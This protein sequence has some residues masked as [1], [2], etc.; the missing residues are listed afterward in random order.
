[1]EEILAK[2]DH[3]LSDYFCKM[4]SWNPYQH[5]ESRRI[6]LEIIGVP[7]Q[8][9]CRDNFEKIAYIWGELVC[10]DT[11]TEKGEN[12][13]VGKMLIDTRHL[14]TIDET[15]YMYAESLGFKIRVKECHSFPILYGSRES[16]GRNRLIDN[17]ESYE[18]E[19]DNSE[20][21]NSAAPTPSIVQDTFNAEDILEGVGERLD[22]NVDPFKDEP[23]IENCEH[24]CLYESAEEKLEELEESHTRLWNVSY[25][26]EEECQILGCKNVVDNDSFG[27]ENI[28]SPSHPPGFENCISAGNNVSNS[29]E[30]NND[31]NLRDIHVSFVLS[32]DDF[33]EVL[34]VEQIKT[35]DISEL[36]GIK[37]LEKVEKNKAGKKRKT[38]SHK[39]PLNNKGK[40]RVGSNIE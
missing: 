31:G 2:E 8:C 23:P 17:L 4:Y 33:D 27:V 29:S 1:M 9:W 26:W 40:K 21:R 30:V 38:K 15:I 3:L 5:C 20:P 28:N 36:L 14:K 22:V 6:W 13:M 25:D 7:P 39:T 32:D 37:F 35:K 12:L 11:S 16:T 24:N 18:W 10:L 19:S 34:E